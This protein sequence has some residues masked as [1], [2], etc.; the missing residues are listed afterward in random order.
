LYWWEIRTDVVV[1]LRVTP[2]QHAERDDYIKAAFVLVGDP[3]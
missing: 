2:L 3:D 1:T